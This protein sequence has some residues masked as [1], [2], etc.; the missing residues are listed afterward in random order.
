LRPAKGLSVL[1]PI[2]NSSVFRAVS[3]Q[4]RSKGL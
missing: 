1:T 2:R 4:F 3:A